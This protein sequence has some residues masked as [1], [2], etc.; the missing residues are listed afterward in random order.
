MINLLQNIYIYILLVKLLHM[1]KY[2]YAVTE[3]TQTGSGLPSMKLS[4]DQAKFSDALVSVCLH[5]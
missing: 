4:A 1:K 5:P 2:F 3:H